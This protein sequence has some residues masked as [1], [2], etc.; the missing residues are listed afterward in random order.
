MLRTFCGSERFVVIVFFDV[1]APWLRT[2]DA[3]V[4]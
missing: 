1:L 2:S 3:T 4:V